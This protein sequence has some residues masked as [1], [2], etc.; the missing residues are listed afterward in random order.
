MG[1]L[2]VTSRQRR[3][4]RA[5]VGSA[6]KLGKL[7]SDGKCSVCSETVSE[8]TG[9][10]EGC[11]AVYGEVHRCPHCRSIADVEASDDLR[12]RCKVCGGPRVVVDDPSIEREFGENSA[13]DLA[14][15]A[16]TR[17]TAWQLGSAVVAGFGVIALLVALATLAVVSPGLGLTILTLLMVAAPFV[18]ATL[19]FR[20][21]K[22]ATKERDTA[23]DRAWTS[24]AKEIAAAKP[25]LDAKQLSKLMRIDEAHAELVLA[26]LSVDDFVRARVE[27]PPERQRVTDVA[28][29]AEIEAAEVEEAEARMTAKVGA[30]SQS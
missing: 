19:G 10:C 6:R 2:R 29:E 17:R 21:A 18:F 7:P 11:G 28:S 30:D 12:F 20:K 14:R 4:K 25:D 13:L 15:K 3:A 5:R 26:Q 9:R 1:S 22:T 8:T 27:A 16:H 23:I 24:V